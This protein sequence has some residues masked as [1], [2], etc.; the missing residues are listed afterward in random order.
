MSVVNKTMGVTDRIPNQ[1]D[2]CDIE[3]NP[4]Y[5]EQKRFPLSIERNALL[6]DNVRIK[7]FA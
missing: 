6:T 1:T 3:P 7:L 4:V 2:V 5:I